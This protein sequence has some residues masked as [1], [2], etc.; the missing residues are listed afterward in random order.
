MHHRQSWQTVQCS[1]L[2][3]L[4]QSFRESFASS[5]GSY[6]CDFL[7]FLQEPEVLPY[8]RE[9]KRE[10]Y[11]I[12]LEVSPGSWTDGVDGVGA[13]AFSALL[14]CLKARI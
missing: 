14:C 13:G 7:V 11:D 1:L 12:N 2:L 6:K 4:K 10:T 8:L 9:Q 5:G 3:A